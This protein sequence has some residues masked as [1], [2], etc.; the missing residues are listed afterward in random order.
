MLSLLELAARARCKWRMCSNPGHGPLVVASCLS[1]LPLHGLCQRIGNRC[2]DGKGM[3]GL[4]WNGRFC[5]G[6]QGFAHAVEVHPGH[7]CES[8]GSV[9]GG[10]LLY[11][12]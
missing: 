2:R 6:D 3:E 1:F 12:F 8:V 7:Q 4:R 11:R 5:P 10:V 9:A